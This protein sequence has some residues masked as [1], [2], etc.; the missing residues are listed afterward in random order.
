M[1]EEKGWRKAWRLSVWRARSDFYLCITSTSA[2]FLCSCR[3]GME[4]QNNFRLIHSKFNRGALVNHTRAMGNSRANDP[5]LAQRANNYIA[6]PGSNPDSY[7]NTHPSRPLNK[8]SAIV[9]SLTL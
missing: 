5:A 9:M 7:T 4:H 3:G 6:D 2:G 8:H 1:P